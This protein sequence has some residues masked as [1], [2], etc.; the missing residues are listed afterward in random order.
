MAQQLAGIT[1]RRQLRPRCGKWMPNAKEWCRRLPGHDYA[2]R[3]SYDME[4]QAAKRRLE[5]VPAHR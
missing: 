3:S 4:N 2:C 1:D 5:Y